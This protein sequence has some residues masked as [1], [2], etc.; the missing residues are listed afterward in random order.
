MNKWLCIAATLIQ[1]VIPPPVA[2]AQCAIFE[3]PADLF[4]RADVVFAGTVVGKQATGAGGGHQIVDVAT[5][6]VEEFGKDV[7]P[8]KSRL[9]F[10]VQPLTD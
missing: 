5:F 10:G 1:L 7:Q 8:V 6:R 3:N 2:S 9:A 4:A